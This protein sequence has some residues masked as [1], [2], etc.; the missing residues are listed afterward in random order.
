M[1]SSGNDGNTRRQS[2]TAGAY[3][4][5]EILRQPL[6]WSTSLKQLRESALLEALAKKYGGA[7][8]WVFIGCGSSFYIAQCAAASM[9]ELS[10]KRARAVPASEIGMLLLQNGPAL[11]GYG[12]EVKVNGQ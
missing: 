10:G 3:T 5:A 2:S 7:E 9:A 11:R 12:L 4:I 8:E 6:S 1:S